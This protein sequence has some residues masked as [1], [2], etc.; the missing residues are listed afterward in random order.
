M[1]S[2]EHSTE[3]VFMLPK[4][5]PTAEIKTTTHV[6]NSAGNY[7]ITLGRDLLSKIGLHALFSDKS[8]QWD[9]NK[10]PMKPV[11]S[12]K[13]THFFVQECK[14]LEAESDR[15]SKI[16]D[17]KYKPADLHKVAG[18]ATGLSEMQKEQL[19]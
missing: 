13:G 8:V 16:L 18:N 17:A 9:G 15:L 14:S 3:L 12:T 5:N 4:L 1:F 11:N 2:T 7:S 19:E 10:V 6:V